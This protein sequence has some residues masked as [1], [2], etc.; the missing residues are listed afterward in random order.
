MMNPRS[1]LLMLGMALLPSILGAWDLQGMQVVMF[2]NK[3]NGKYL[4]YDAKTKGL[5]LA[6]KPGPSAKWLITRPLGTGS[7][8]QICL[9][10]PVHISTFQGGLML[11]H[12]LGKTEV[13]NADNMDGQ[14]ENWQFV[15]P[16]YFGNKDGIGANGA[17]IGPL[18]VG[19]PGTLGGAVDCLMFDPMFKPGT[20]PGGPHS[21]GMFHAT[22]PVPD[23]GRWFIVK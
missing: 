20:P 17:Q 18:I 1:C 5:T 23:V 3:H 15:D 21:Y 4:A 2:K 6:D 12:D 7:G 22:G 11:A 9:N 16:G 19:A 8:K 10:D 13:I 14:K